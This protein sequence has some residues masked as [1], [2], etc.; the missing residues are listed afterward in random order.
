MTRLLTGTVLALI[1]S[2]F[3]VYWIDD[4]KRP[5]VSAKEPAA[6]NV[7]AAPHEHVS[8]KA[9]QASRVPK[10]STEARDLNALPPTL[11]PALFTGNPKLAYEVAKEIPQ[12]LAQLPCYCHCDMSA[13][14]QSLHSCFVTEHGEACGIC[15]NEALLAYGLEK[16]H[17]LNPAQIRERIIAAYGDRNEP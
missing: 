1:V 5:P 2:A 7:N 4:N 9:R 15:I 10:Y 17:K 13:G 6:V 8:H 12:T 14:H 3:I 11:S 16:R